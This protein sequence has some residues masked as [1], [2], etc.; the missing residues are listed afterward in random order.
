MNFNADIIDTRAYDEIHE[1]RTTPQI[2]SAYDCINELRVTLMLEHKKIIDEKNKEKNANEKLFELLGHKN[3][4][5]SK[6]PFLGVTIF[7]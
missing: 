4:Y 5:I 7:F 3:C 1:T 2:K 6:M